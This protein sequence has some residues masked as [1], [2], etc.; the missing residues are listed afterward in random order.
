MPAAARQGDPTAHGGTI[1]AGE[2]TVLINGMPA[3]R[4]G[5]MHMCPMYNGDTP[6]VGGPIMMGAPTVLING[7]PAARMGDVCVCTGPPDT[8]AMG[9]PTVQ[10]RS[11]GNPVMIGG[12]GPVMIGGSGP[13]IIGG[14]SSGGGGGG[15]SGA[16]AQGA[17]ASAAAAAGGSPEATELVE[18]WLDFTFEDK[19][20]NAMAGVPYRLE[21][22]SGEPSEDWLRGGGKIRRSGLEEGEGT[23]TVRGLK[24][25]EW[26]KSEAKVGETVTVTAT[27]KG[28]EGGTGATVQITEVPVEG[29]EAA[30]V[31]EIETEVSGEE[32]EAEWTYT[33]EAVNT[34]S[35]EAP[36]GGGSAQQM[37]AYRAEV[38]VE[39]HPMPSL[40][41]LLTYDDDLEVTLLDKKTE[42][43]LKEHPYSLRLANGEIRTGKTDGS[44][45]IK[46]QD[47]PPGPWTLT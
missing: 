27:A 2:P 43:P 4:Q 22:P 34:G 41:G 3:A 9:E 25:A 32:V 13:V 8:I 38:R 5:D 17:V 14:G 18:H 47:V 24:G 30:I 45:K 1:A 20:G 11:G 31:K 12:S 36:A 23:A 39:G 35:E 42:K 28:V 29:G 7:M 33:H 10:I 40:T 16:G 26:S 21:P 37:P 44:G 6:H 15:G 46:E 19:A